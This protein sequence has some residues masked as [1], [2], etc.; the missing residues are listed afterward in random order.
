MSPSP[1]SVDPLVRSFVASIF[2]RRCARCELI[3]LVASSLALLFAV[4]YFDLDRAL[5]RWSDKHHWLG[6]GLNEIIFVS[7]IMCVGSAIFSLRRWHEL[8]VEMAARRQAEDSRNQLAAIVEFSNDAIIGKDLNGI[9]TSWNAAAENLYDYSAAEAIGR[10]VELIIPTDRSHEWQEILEKIREGE[11]ISHFETE[12]V[13]KNGQRINVSLSVSPIKSVTGDVVGAAVIARD[14]SE[15][16]RLQQQLLQSRKVEAIGRLAGGV[17]HDFNNILTTIIGYCDLTREELGADHSARVNIEEIAGAAERAA[18]LTRQ[19]LAFSRKQTLQ[20]KILD[21]NAVIENLDKMLRRVIGEDVELIT[22]LTPNLGRVK[23]DPGQIEQVIMNL[24]V[25]ARDAMP[26]GGRLLLETASVTLDAASAHLPE[27]VRPGNYVMIAVTDT[28]TG[29]TDEVKARVFEPFFTT[30]PRGQGTGLG[31]PTCYGIIKQ[32][33][34]H[35]S[36]YSEFTHGTTFKIF[37][38]RIADPTAPCSPAPPS[39]TQR[40]GTETILLVEDDSAV[41][42]LNARLLRSAGYTVVEADN[43]RTALRLTDERKGDGID[44]LL[45]DVIMPEM[46]GKELAQRLQAAYPKMKVMFCSGYT[47]EAIDRGGV[48][49]PHTAFLQKP[50]TPALLTQKIREVLDTQPTAVRDANSV[51]SAG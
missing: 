32:S 37:L 8:A 27:D 44:L 11:H 2:R 1:C 28:G 40:R 20:P 48:L 17:A 39:V 26:N 51:T 7:G 35:I 9:I 15:R 21:L 33:G 14:I 4:H 12:R 31:L 10:S 13:G 16:Q 25:N 49:N 23:A 22:K 45:T 24:A 29:M 47:Q 18:S 46:G 50:F 42:T 34:G 3:I 38:P 43:G 6:V 30:K 5:D 36:V 41:R 19:L